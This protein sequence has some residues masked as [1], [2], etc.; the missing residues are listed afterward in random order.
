MS[1]DQMATN[2]PIKVSWPRGADGFV[3]EAT[4]GLSPASWQAVM[5][6]H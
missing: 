4:Q 1:I 6:D 2:H 5:R 3:L